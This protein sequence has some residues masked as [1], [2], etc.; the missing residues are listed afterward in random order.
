MNRREALS[1]VAFLM[2]TAVVGAEAFLSGCQRSTT[3]EE[4]FSQKRGRLAQ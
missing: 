4:L 3:S 2:G 1:A